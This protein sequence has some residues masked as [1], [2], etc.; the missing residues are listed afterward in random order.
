MPCYTWIR[1][2]DAVENKNKKGQKCKRNAE[3]DVL[4]LAAI[5]TA[6]MFGRETEERG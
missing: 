1:C 6:V 5:K 2:S 3:R 4:L